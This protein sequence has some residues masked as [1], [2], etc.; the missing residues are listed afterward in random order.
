MVWCSNTS[1]VGV[2]QD[3]GIRLF[4]DKKTYFISGGI[5][6]YFFSWTNSKIQPRWRY[7]PSLHTKNWSILFATRSLL[8]AEEIQGMDCP[9]GGWRTGGFYCRRQRKIPKPP[10]FCC[11]VDVF[12]VAGV[13]MVM[14][15]SFLSF[16]FFFKGLFNSYLNNRYVM[17]TWLYTTGKCH[18]VEFSGTPQVSSRSLTAR[19]PEA[20]SSSCPAMAFRGVCCETSGVMNHLSP[21][22]L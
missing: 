20:G 2:K 21:L 19:A 6:F 13:F 17:A 3:Y 11:F 14:V 1:G 16:S 22:W 10:G 4:S 7:T 5:H 8:L 18:P 15:R 9:G 12:F